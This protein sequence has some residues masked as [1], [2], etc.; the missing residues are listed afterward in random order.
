MRR[1]RCADFGKTTY[2][3]WLLAL[4]ASLLGLII[5]KHLLIDLYLMYKKFKSV[6]KYFSKLHSV[7]QLQIVNSILVL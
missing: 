6:K 3:G 7:K 1:L 4:Y 5:V 2:S